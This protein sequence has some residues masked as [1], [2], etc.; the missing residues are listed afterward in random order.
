MVR[1]TQSSDVRAPKGIGSIRPYVVRKKDRRD[2]GEIVKNKWRIR[3]PTG[4]GRKDYVFT[5]TAKQADTYRYELLKKA[6]KE[7]QAE[8]RDI[9]FG[10][11]AQHFYDVQLGM[12]KKSS[13]KTKEYYATILDNHVLPF[14]GNI[15]LRDIKKVDVDKFILELGKKKKQRGNKPLASRTISH[16]MVVF[17]AV[18]HDAI[19]SEIIPNRP[20]LARVPSKFSSGEAKRNYAIPRA[21]VSALMNLS[22]SRF[23]GKYYYFLAL[24]FATGAHLG[25]LMGLTW[26]DLDLESTRPTVSF[27]KSFSYRGNW[28]IDNPLD[29]PV[30]KDLKNSYRHR[31]LAIDQKTASAMREYKELARSRLESLTINSPVFVH[32]EH[33]RNLSSLPV[34]PERDDTFTFKPG[35]TF[36]EYARHYMKVEL[37][38][39]ASLDNEGEVGVGHL[40]HLKVCLQRLLPIIEEI[41]IAELNDNWKETIYKTLLNTETKKR[42]PSDFKRYPTKLGAKGAHDTIKALDDVLLQALASNPYMAKPEAPKDTGLGEL[43]DPSRT[44]AN[45]AKMMRE[46]RF[47]PDFTLKSTRHTHAT[48]LLLAGVAISTVAERLGHSSL[49][50]IYNHYQHVLDQLDH[51]VVEALETLDYLDSEEPNSKNSAPKNVPILEKVVENV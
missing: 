23:G 19:A 18:F 28:R 36:G 50:M 41:P 10:E 8:N 29:N 20:W 38:K 48:D 47:H 4:S 30:Y 6:A 42:W 39:C 45:C 5:G 1:E 22:K 7:N 44:A 14:F 24:A 35:T 21:E 32:L 46:L 25:E 9:T 49:K 15:K 12:V 27:S 37:D 31:K 16:I 11:Y 43:W 13:P 51:Q 34:I 33:F 3:I 40:K 26:K 2:H 17:R